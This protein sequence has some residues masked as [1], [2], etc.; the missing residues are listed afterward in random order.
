MRV[1]SLIPMIGLLGMAG[2]AEAGENLL[3]YTKGAEVLPKG[4]AELY[5]WITQR[6]DKG[7]GE[8]TAYDLKT[9][10]EYGFT[11]RFNMTGAFLAQS[12]ETSGLIIDGYLP[13]EIDTGL[14]PAG[15]KL[16]AKYNFLSPAADDFGL[17]ME[18]EGQYM[19][20]DPHSGQDKD[21]FTVELSMY[22]QKY[23]LEGQ[24][25]WLGNLGMESTYAHRAD[26]DGL[27]ADFDWPTEPEME[28]GIAAKTGLSY[29]FVP[30]WYIGAEIF[31]EEEFE[32]EVGSERWSVFAGPS[33][34]YG[35]ARWWTTLTWVAQLKGGGEVYEGQT[36][37]DLHLIEKTRDEIRLKVGYNF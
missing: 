7:Q 14:E 16:G 27:P 8:Y 23:F 19:W 17:T 4:A 22:M 31:Y 1:K 11:N 35:G 6:T 29:R 9:E 12:I 5:Q 36:E 32:T 10:V 21:T 18:V 30:N 28:I 20:K 34:H 2:S 26:I 15:V 13:E 37:Q 33:I 3:G 24:M 25:V